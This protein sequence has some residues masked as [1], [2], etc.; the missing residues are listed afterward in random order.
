MI[1]VLTRRVDPVPLYEAAC[2]ELMARGFQ[3]DLSLTP[4]DRTVFATDNSIYQVEPGAVAFPRTRDDIVR[5]ARLLDDPRFGGIV[6]RPRGGG[7]GTNGQ[8]L[9]EGLVVDTS[10]HMNRILEIDVANRT[11]R[12]EPGVVKD[13]LNR[14]L[15]KHGLFFAPELSTSNRATIGGMISTDACGQGSCLYGKT[16]DHVLALTCV[17][18]DGAVWTAEPLDDVGLAA[19]KAQP[20]RVGEVHRVVDTA[21]AG[22]AALIAE[23]FPRLN[24]CLTGYDLAHV[25]DGQ[26]RFDLKSLICGS[27]GTLALIAEARLN[28]LPIPEA[29]ALVALSYVD[30]DAALRDAQALMPFGAASVETIDSTVLALA[31]RDPIWAEVQ[32]FFPD[33][34]AGRSVEGINLVEFVGDGEDAVGE[35]LSRLTTVLDAERGSHTTRIGY[36]VARGPAIERLWTMRKKAVGLLGA[37]KGEARPIPFV[38]DTAVPPEVL[39]DYIAEF[40]ALLDAKGLRYGMF[41]HVDAGVLHVRPAIDLKDEAQAPLIR[42]VTEAVVALTKRYGGLL[43]GEHGKGFRS[44][45]VPETFGPLVPVLEAVKRAFDPGDRMNPGKIASAAGQPLTRIDG[46]PRRGEA[47]RT[48]PTPVRAEFDAALHCNGNGACFSFDTDEA[49]CPSWK[50]TRERRHSPKGRASLMREWLR[51]AAAAGAD[52]AAALRAERPNWLA[53]ILRSLRPA[54]H[55]DDFS[56]AVKEAMDGCLACK[57]CTGSCP[58][59]VDVPS[60]RAKFLALYHQRYPRPL[61]D[62][63]IAALEPLLPLAARMPRL[64]NAVMGNPLSRAVLAR[65]GLVAIPTL[66]T[67]DLAG[68]LAALHAAT[69]TPA[70][71]RALSAGERERS[72]VVV[73]D[74]FTTHFEAELVADLCALLKEL[75]FRPWLAPYR[76]NGKP[77]HV[78]GFLARFGQVAADSASS[79]I[80]LAAE[81][82]PLVGI[83]PS[84]TLTYRSEYAAALPAGAVPQVQMV[85]EWLA[86]RLDAVAPRAGGGTYRLLPHCTERTNAPGAVKDWQAVFRHLGLALDVPAAGCCGMAGTYGHEASHRATSET[87]YRQSWAQRVRESAG[88]L[89]A[90]GYSCRSQ[91]KLIDG[92][93]LRHPV[94]ALLDHVRASAVAAPRKAAA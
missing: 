61:K 51:L 89:L 20:G 14:E 5:I 52:P 54:G 66:S 64:G 91:A 32:A 77:L 38:E 30:F 88:D 15:A 3:G 4:A 42:E 82:V 94:R 28:V 63:L 34:P 67:F 2:A 12:V 46:V 27:E 36:T 7:T 49:M 80:A 78:H 25:R 6:I 48:I 13:Q 22:N 40:R 75:G 85:Q 26:G 56:H 18:T 53:D 90:D 37:A 45:F 16:R 62:H 24:R 39:A 33:D 31:R 72:V 71:L 81:G 92:V 69:A 47:D 68:A 17:L 76:P 35:A 73:Q 10:R 87:I 86:G 70:A 21:I 41:G 93:R 84:M 50:A 8:S 43:W 57:S 1:P 74:A 29:S 83:D 59:K 58:I 79:L 23:R 55:R 44:E 19:A 65:L 9:G 60:F 11:V